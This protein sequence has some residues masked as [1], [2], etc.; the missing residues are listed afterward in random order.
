M[1][2]LTTTPLAAADEARLTQDARAKGIA[3]RSVPYTVLVEALQKVCAEYD[4]ALQ[5]IVDDYIDFMTGEKLLYSPDDWLLAFSCGISYNENEKYCLYYCS[6]SRPRRQEC[7]FIGIYKD[8]V[9]SLIGEISA[10][11]ICGYQEGEVK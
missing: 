10:V 8:K 6:P 5:A 2:G 11:M 7:R 4:V 3:F 1:I 9:V